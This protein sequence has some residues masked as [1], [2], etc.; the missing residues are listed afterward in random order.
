MNTNRR[1]GLAALAVLM[2]GIL[3]IWGA[4]SPGQAP[5][6]RPAAWEYTQMYAGN[7]DHRVE[8]NKLGA[9]GW[10]LVTAYNTDPQKP[11]VYVFK[12]VKP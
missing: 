2:V 6:G 4:T 11:V 3:T 10:E 1:V 8:L 9:Q 7:G 5:A 12:R